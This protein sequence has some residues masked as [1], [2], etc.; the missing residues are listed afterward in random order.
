[1][2]TGRADV[3]ADSPPIG[4]CFFWWKEEEMSCGDIPGRNSNIC[5]ELEAKETRIVLG[6]ASSSC[7]A[8]AYEAGVERTKCGEV[9][10]A[11]S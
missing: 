9:A 8:G 6:I 7:V 10:G 2:F 3:W 5:K 11:I 1:M 4:K